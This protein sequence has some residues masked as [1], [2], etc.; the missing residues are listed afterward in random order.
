MKPQLQGLIAAYVAGVVFGV[1]WILLADG[2]HAG[3][4]WR[5]G[6]LQWNTTDVYLIVPHPNQPSFHF[7][8]IFPPIFVTV[9][10]ILLNLSSPTRLSMSGMSDV[11]HTGDKARVW[12]FLTYTLAGL[13][14]AGS[15]WIATQ[16]YP[17][18][19]LPSAAQLTSYPGWALVG[20]N[21]LLVLSG[22]LFFAS[23]GLAAG[24][25]PMQVYM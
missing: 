11:N 18:P 1:A 16:N 20:N 6:V 9:A 25:S 8:Y 12:V 24:E 5:E 15:F 22:S 23:S 21:L 17:D 10:M 2:I 3:V 4:N 13:C 19:D 14:T 7:S